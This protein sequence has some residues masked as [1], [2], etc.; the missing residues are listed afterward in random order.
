MFE[1]LLLKINIPT[2]YLWDRIVSIGYRDI[3]GR[4]RIEVLIV[5]TVATLQIYRHTKSSQEE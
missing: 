1:L 4:Y 5:G 3:H 2:S